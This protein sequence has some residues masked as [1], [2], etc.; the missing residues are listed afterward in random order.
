MK[1]DIICVVYVDNTILVGP[2]PVALEQE[3][4]GLGVSD[5]EQQQHTFKLRDEGAVG[6]F[7]GIRIE[8]RGM[9]KM[10]GRPQSST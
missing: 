10:T 3:I 8:K 2:N 1:K 7:L 5:G 4:D 6:D 9:N